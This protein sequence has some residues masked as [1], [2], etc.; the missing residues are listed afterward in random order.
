MFDMNKYTQGVVRN[1][2]SVH[3]IQILLHCGETHENETSYMG[4]PANCIQI[5]NFIGKLVNKCV[6]SSYIT[7]T[8]KI[9]CQQFSN[10]GNTCNV[11]SEE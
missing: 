11:Q 1:T 3:G 2:Y 9:K 4:T 7:N 8:R 5:V 10:N 6:P